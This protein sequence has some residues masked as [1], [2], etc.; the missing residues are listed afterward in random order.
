MT[1]AGFLQKLRDAVADLPAADRDAAIEYFTE[2]LDDRIEE[3]MT[4]GEAVDSLG[5]FADIVAALHDNAAD[6]VTAAATDTV[7]GETIR[8]RPAVYDT[9]DLPKV[10][11]LRET[12][13]AVE[14][15]PAADGRLRIEYDVTRW[16]EV[17]LERVGDTL[18]YTAREIPHIFHFDFI[19]RKPVRVYLP[20]GAGIDRVEL[21]TSNAKL[22]ARD[23]S[24]ANLKLHTSNASVI[25]ERIEAADLGVKS[26][27]G[28]VHAADLKAAN[29]GLTTSN[30]SIRAERL[31][32]ANVG[33][34]TSNGSIHADRLTAANL[35]AKSSNASVRVDTVSATV[36]DLTTSN[37]RIE[38]QNVAESLAD[39]A[40]VTS[41]AS[42]A[43]TLPG[44]IADY[45]I[46]SSGGNLPKQKNSGTKSLRAKT[47]NGKI[48]I[49]FIAD[50]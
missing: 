29:L 21:R 48:N 13:C 8:P 37:G 11:A 27:N 40:L 38:L 1:K 15:L 35:A 4:E 49:D 23:V 50:R 45:R 6:A 9:A 5:A 34:T 17:N 41:N 47:S 43:A 2:Q 42:V 24:H 44:S 36:I 30:G 32:G 46:V 16:V 20:Q 7:R 26:S 31:E 33:L 25:A 12:N 39:V 19:S 14:L 28:S 10:L 3:G 18:S 22:S